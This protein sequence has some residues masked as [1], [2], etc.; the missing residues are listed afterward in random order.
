M[1]A[2]QRPPQGLFH[3][4]ILLKY[5]DNLQKNSI[6][7]YA[8]PSWPQWC[9]YLSFP[10]D[11]SHLQQRLP[12]ELAEFSWISTLPGWHGCCAELPGPFIFSTLLHQIEGP[13]AIWRTPVEGVTHVTPA[14][15]GYWT[16][17]PLR[18]PRTLRLRDLN[19][20]QNQKREQDTASRKPRS[21]GYQKKKKK[22][23]IYIYIYD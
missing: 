5:H 6:T 19:L 10:K 7:Q 20:F 21:S 14:S 12:L 23:Y 3:R 11:S 9:S 1:R 13:T 2:V 15:T 22:M 4:N 8:Q 16:R 18:F 17:C